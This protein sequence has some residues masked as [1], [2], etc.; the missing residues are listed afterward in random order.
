MQIKVNRRKFLKTASATMGM[1]ACGSEASIA[2]SVEEHHGPAIPAAS[3]VGL[4][5]TRYSPTDYPIRPKEFTEVTLKDTFWLPKIK[6]NAQVTIPFEI[7]KF[8]ERERPIVNNVV[9]GAIYSLQTYPDDAVQ[10]EVNA[11]VKKI[12]ETEAAR[13]SIR[14]DFFEVA[15]AYYTATGKKDLLDLATARAD[16]IYAVFEKDNP[17][18]SGGE[19]DAINCIQLYKATHDTRYLDMA[20][21]YLDIR[22]QENSVNRSRHNQSYKP[23]LEQSEAVGHAVNDVTLMVSLVEVGM[24]TG[25]KEYFDAAERIWN[26][27]V[28]RKLYITGGVGSTGNEGFGQAY[29]L[30]NLSAY[31]ETCAAAM[32]STFNH[33]MFLA[34][35]NGK[36]ID[37]MERTMYNNLTDG[38]SA[39]G[40][41]F[42]YVNRLA[43]VGTGRDVR[44]ERASLE[45]CPPNL[46]RFMASMPGYVYAQSG[47]N[48]YVNL[49]ISSE[50]TFK[51]G[52][53]E[54]SLSVDS[55]M[56]W[57]GKSTINVT[58]GVGLKAT[59]KL[60][61]PGWLQNRPVPSDLYSFMNESDAQPAISVNGTPAKISMDA[62]GYVSFDRVWKQGDTVE[63]NFPLEVRRVVANPKVRENRG[64]MA[65][66]RGPIVFC[67]EWP[68]YEGGHILTLLV[69][70]E[71]ELKP[72]VEQSFYGGVI[73]LHGQAKQISMPS[74]EFHPLKLIPYYLWANR[75]AGE[76]TVW[77]SKED[78]KIGDVGPAGGT[79]FYCNKNYAKDGWR[80]LE[81][82]PFD[83]SAGAPW[84]SF[85]I[86]FPG[87]YGTAVG[88]GKQNTADIL[89]S[90]E[91]SGIAAN[92]C[93][94]FALHGT[95]D[96][97]LPSDD[98][99]V[100]MYTNL[101][102]TKLVDFG[103]SHVPDNY[104]YWSSSQ[105]TTDMAH[106]RDFADDAVRGHY[107]D[108][109]YPRRVRAIR[110]F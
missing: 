27:V 32:F 51:V 1:L 62:L 44:W 108:K 65:V 102:V 26:D 23:V 45:C 93:A 66:E 5:G 4:S 98:E 91:T 87:A 76:M 85:R 106:H 64:R 31:C 19:R 103:D 22:G 48:L 109:D 83:Q 35:G 52:G 78:Y 21:H 13:P 86:P 46:V 107:D 18:F 99:L 30:P 105:V 54:I 92:L 79:I 68:D 29:S 37:V 6:T 14:N 60:R 25:L 80:F 63:I 2:A 7:Q 70:P 101:A 20:K 38:V 28:Q 34:T 33:K 53:E 100:L 95:R 17:P 81:A 82:A 71:S 56:P 15:V 10:A 90:C 74:S 47:N 73:I 50:T 75:G 67:A 94:N 24:L 89:A 42:F 96:W 59:L 12:A 97:F 49:Y 58:K 3:A 11:A 57:G 36:Y 110:S 16:R 61:I 8:H 41:H 69:P 77:L 9:Q 40:N 39:S 88:T 55:E 104:D 43:S 84:G 72:S